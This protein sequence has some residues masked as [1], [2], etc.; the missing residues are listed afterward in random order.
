MIEA[1][2]FFESLIRFTIELKSE[3]SIGNAVEKRSN[4]PVVMT[5]AS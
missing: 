5:A 1:Y 3:I 4:P 2:R